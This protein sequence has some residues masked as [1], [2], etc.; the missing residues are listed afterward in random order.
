M[1]RSRP[2]F[3]GLFI[4]G[5]L[6]VAIV[7]ALTFGGVRWFE[8]SQE[9][10]IYF[11]EGLAGLS[12]GSPVTFRGIEIGTVRR[13]AIERGRD[14]SSAEL[15]VFVDL[16]PGDILVSDGEE[17]ETLEQV[18]IE[19]LVEEGLKGRLVPRSLLTGQMSINLDFHP[20][21]EAEFRSHGEL[22]EIPSLRSEFEQARSAIMEF[23]WQDTL[24]TV[25]STL[26]S[27]DRLSRAMESEL[28]G[29]G[30]EVRLTLEDT[31]ALLGRASETIVTLERRA[32]GSFD[33]FDRLATDTRDNIER[34]SEEFD[35]AIAEARETATRVNSAVDE[36]EVVLDPRSEERDDLRR[37][38]RDLSDTASSL[39]R[40]AD[41]VERDPRALIF[42]RGD[43]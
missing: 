12:A 3:L 34:S 14:P 41:R 2:A 39:S 33:R 21:E 1:N 10:V 43:E 7:G 25:V 16:R 40:F 24:D 20:D 31:Q 42:G 38:L 28:V 6:I 29:L 5:G 13:M 9:A 18:G 36:L 26:E 30:D 35:R 19:S 8:P 23:P 32:E 22:P 27:L 11:D 4:L 37:T 15:P 17:M